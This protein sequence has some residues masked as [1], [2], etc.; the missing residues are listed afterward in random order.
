MSFI[1][2][3][4][5][6]LYEHQSTYNPNMPL[7]G[8]LYAVD[9]YRK[10]IGSIEKLYK[11][12]LVKLP[13]P[14]YVVFYNGDDNNIEDVTSLRL[15]D[16]FEEQDKSGDYEWTATV[17][18]INSGYNKQLMDE[19]PILKQYS[20]FIGKIKKYSKKYDIKEAVDIAVDEA[21]EEDILKDFLID[22]RQEVNDMY[23]AEFDEKK[24]EAII[25]EEEREEGIQI[26]IEKGIEQGEDI[27]NMK[28]VKHA[29]S[30]GESIEAIV[31]FTGLSYETVLNYAN[32]NI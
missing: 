23:L 24:W 3:S 20:D 12:K 15:S 21:I 4:S 6:N 5:M 11:R 8:M 26:G 25:R 30:Q 16:A 2:G 18:N 31:L 19:C 28:V 10:Y 17:I 9:V 22:H 32:Q 29:I 13:N 1:V 14:K 7:R 27:A